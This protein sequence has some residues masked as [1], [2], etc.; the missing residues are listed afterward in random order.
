MP[1]A[2][3]ENAI[4]AAEIPVQGL[5]PTNPERRRRRTGGRRAQEA[6]PA[7]E[8]EAAVP[9]ADGADNQPPVEGEAT[10]DEQ[11]GRRLRR[12]RVGGR[13]G[14]GQR[15]EAS[16]AEAVAEGQEESVEA[17]AAPA[18]A[19]ESGDQDGR[20]P[21]R[22]RRGG[23]RRGVKQEGTLTESEVE[24]QPA[25]EEFDLSLPQYVPPPFWR[26]P[27]LVPTCEELS[28]EA[29][30]LRVN[31]RLSLPDGKFIID[32]AETE[33]QIMF[34]NTETASDA[35]VVENQ[36]RL[37]SQIGVHLF[38]AVTY[39]PLK[40]AYGERS[41]ARTDEVLTQL[42]EADPDARIILRLQCA[43]TN[44]WARVHPGEL[45]KYA[46][47]SD[48]DVSFAS[49]EFWRASVGAIGALLHH[50]ADPATFGG[51]RV[52]GLH[53]D[54]GEWFHDAQAGYD[55]SAPNRR[56]F[57]QW[58]HEK[59]QSVYALRAAWR[60]GSVDFDSAEIPAWTAPGGTDKPYEPAIYSG[61]KDRRYTDYH[62]YSSDIVAEAIVGLAEAVKV[63]SDGRLLVGASYGY[64]FEFAHRNDSGHQSL[65]K[66]LA[67]PAVDVLAGPNS[68]SN[69]AAG[70]AGAFCSPVDS[71]RL[72]GKI[73]IVED[74]TKTHL[75]AD[76]TEDA[77]NPKIGTP[78]DT[79]SVHRRNALTA[80]VHRAGINWMD[81][82]GQG[83]LNSDS[84][85]SDIDQFREQ[86]RYANI[87]R[88]ASTESAPEVAVI[89]DEASFAY[90]RADGNGLQIQAALIT[91]IRDLL[92]RSGASVG[93][94]LQSDLASVPTDPKVFVFLNAL[95]VTTAER[96]A[97]RERF[98]VSGKTLV[99][100]YAP[101]LFDE[102]G[103][104]HQEVSEIVGQALKRQPWNARI[105]TLFTEERHP[106]IE[107]LHGGKRMGSEEVVNPSYT[108][109]DPQGMVLGEYIQSGVPS[110]VARNMAGGWR[111]VFVGEPHLTGELL[112][113]IFRYA[114][115]H[116]YDL[117]DDIVAAGEGLLMVHAPYTG[118]RTLHL[119][120]QSAVYSVTERRLV[121]EQTSSFRFFMRG[122]STHFFL[123]GALA[124]LSTALGLSFDELR[125]SMQAHRDRQDQTSQN[126][127]GD[128]EERGGYSEQQD[129]PQLSA[130]DVPEVAQIIE[131]VDMP[132]DV[133]S[134]PSEEEV[135]GKIEDPA[136]SGQE[137]ATTPSRRR[138]WNRRRQRARSA[139]SGGPVSLDGLLGDLP[140]RRPTPPASE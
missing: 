92:C 5:E 9:A 55:F 19:G 121:S 15:E 63:L 78:Q 103:L 134:L 51:D 137:A 111:S 69:R 46:N 57:Q 52:V 61:A 42:I 66:V 79:V 3:Q 38:S 80:V 72:H 21:R 99:W 27:R 23:R 32:G 83:W 123:Y 122:R 86:Q 31:A 108:S 34:V 104:T 125:G 56:A 2:P 120:K 98:Q 81:L 13:R 74:D 135:L 131:G 128:E 138:R 91:K 116:V 30:P 48:G 18:D 94:Y 33:P 82:W 73:W 95:R 132:D 133:D 114:G 112:R 25:K 12:R 37:A 87:L 14:A 101:G 88:A 140:E 59:Y 117:Q 39:L 100:M 110:I 49:A 43:P 75:A 113:G 47:G 85:W 17:S 53:L 127:N 106:V 90:A 20:R 28:L 6:G 93:Y 97:I 129:L 11:A 1:I 107:R 29:A 65:H 62:A 70:G 124:Q 136:A 126:G 105:G 84:I 24:E 10:Q 76:D 109:V 26:A 67:S 64:T 22:S 36:I 139:E 119:P 41:F 68:Y 8:V 89:V 54:K 115:V 118:L 35:Q 44:Y 7:P 71:I 77:Y 96:H 102:K 58:L 4:P 50:L 16:T 40:N 45:A 130:L 60:D